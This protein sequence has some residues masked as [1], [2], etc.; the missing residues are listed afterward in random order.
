MSNRNSQKN[1]ASLT[2]MGEVRSFFAAI[3]AEVL[4]R[5]IMVITLFSFGTV[6]IGGMMMYF[7]S[8]PFTTALFIGAVVCMI[9]CFLVLIL[10]SFSDFG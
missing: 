8:A 6:M 3:L 4:A 7:F 10:G 2:F 1:S 9:F 5:L